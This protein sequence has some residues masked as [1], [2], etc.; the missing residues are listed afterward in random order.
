[1]NLVNLDFSLTKVAPNGIRRILCSEQI[2]PLRNE[3]AHL[4]VE[5]G[6][7][8]QEMSLGDVHTQISKELQPNADDG[9]NQV[10]QSFY[11]TNLAFQR[12]YFG[13]IKHLANVMKFDFIFQWV[14]TIRFLFPGP[15]PALFL[16]S[17]G[18]RNHHSDTMLGHPFEEIN[19]WVPFT[20]CYGTNALLMS[21]VQDGV[22]VL[23][24]FCKDINYDA[25]VYHQRGAELFLKKMKTDEHFC[26]SVGEICSPAQ[27][28]FGEVLIFDP[29]CIHATNH[30]TEQHTRISMD[31]R[32]IPLD[33]YEKMTHDYR[34]G[35]RGKRFVRGDLFHPQTAFEL[36]I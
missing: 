25:D 6:F 17:Q 33:L 20:R 13:L 2:L 22:T 32:I 8:S 29:R 27:M 4:L 5:R 36:T 21:S 12:G 34:S 30:N 9:I 11:E 14:P 3:I 10:T 35:R 31:F 23:H 16:T 26:Q 18:Y 1:M 28:E 7:V 24:R 15:M 19:F